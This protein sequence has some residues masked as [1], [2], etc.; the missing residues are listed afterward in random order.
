MKKILIFY[1]NLLLCTLSV[2]TVKAQ[3]GYQPGPGTVYVC[4]VDK[5]VVL[6]GKGGDEYC[7]K[8]EPNENLSD[9]EA[10]NPTA[11]PA[12]D[13]DYTVTVLDGELN[14]ISSQTVHVIVSPGAE[15]EEIVV[16]GSVCCVNAGTNYNHAT[17]NISTIPSNLEG[18]LEYVPAGAPSSTEFELIHAGVKEN[19]EVLIKATCP[20]KG[21]GDLLEEKIHV[22]VVD[23]NFVASAAISKIKAPKG[24]DFNDIFQSIDKLA[25]SVNEVTKNLPKESCNLKFD[26]SFKVTAKYS[27]QCCLEGGDDCIYPKTSIEP[28]GSYVAKLDKCKMNIPI[29]PD[30][31]FISQYLVELYLELSASAGVT[32]GGGFYWSC[33]SGM[34]ACVSFGPVFTLGLSANAQVLKGFGKISAG[35]TVKAT[36]P[37]IKYCFENTESNGLDGDFCLEVVGHFSVS[38]LWGGIT[39]AG[40]TEH[41][42]EEQCLNY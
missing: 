39:I 19:Q 4:D 32:L 24:I 30:G 26:N 31:G 13:K 37:K 25:E 21:G 7:F 34:D 2:H 33:G 28:S 1:I 22:N 16:D 27:A 18:T 17:L 12:V 14:I 5:G 3:S 41:I 8:W 29:L 38:A 11:T 42:I 6:G 15:L 40:F 35:T 9:N 20:T 10:R 23:P 36:T